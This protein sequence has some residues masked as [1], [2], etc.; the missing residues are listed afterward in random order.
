LN[1]RGKSQN[2]TKLQDLAT[3]TTNTITL[4]RCIA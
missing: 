3:M 4:D 2:Q 1:S